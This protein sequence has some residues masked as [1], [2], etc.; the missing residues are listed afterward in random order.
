ML[1]V[2]M[3]SALHTP[4]APLSAY[5]ASLW[6]LSDT[7]SHTRERVIPSSTLELVFNLEENELRIYDATA[8][9]QCR[10]YSGAVV[11]GA[12]DRCFVIDTREH[13]SVIGAHFRPGGALC[14]LG[15]PPGALTR[16]HVDLETLWG[17][18]AR[19]LRERL[20][21]CR[22]PQRRFQILEAALTA[23]LRS[24]RCH[25]AV[26]LALTRLE[27]GAAV[28]D[29]VAEVGLS[30]RRLIEV[31]TAEVGITP[32]LFGRVRRFQR[33]TALAHRGLSPDWARLAAECGYFD[34]S[35]LIRDFI[36]FSGLS[37]SEFVRQSSPLVKDNHLPV[38]GADGSTSSNTGHPHRR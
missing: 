14:V 31:F 22:S 24:V 6:S 10:R 37:P 25:S 15:L 21:A 26:P 34:Q 30:H 36:A 17:P 7:P 11:S 28:R 12:Y 4:A 16:S 18:G 19:T 3:I 32:K 33:A 20:C 23:R 8:S 38:V 2:A 35:H 29:V 9:G 27:H 1:R 5:V 13:A